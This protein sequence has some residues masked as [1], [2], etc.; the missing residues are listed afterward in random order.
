MYS[1]F[2]SVQFCEISGFMCKPIHY[3][4]TSNKYLKKKKENLVNINK[5]TI[6]SSILKVGCI[7]LFHVHYRDVNTVKIKSKHK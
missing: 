5:Q 2:F 1:L 6:I 7:S 3:I 4:S